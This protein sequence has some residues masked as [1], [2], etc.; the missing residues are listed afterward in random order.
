MGL[1][2]AIIMIP[3]VAV[4]LKLSRGTD[5]ELK[6]AEFDNAVANFKTSSPT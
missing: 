2:F 4:L 3:N 6:R 1:P 5:E